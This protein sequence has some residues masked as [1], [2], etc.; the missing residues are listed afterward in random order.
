MLVLS[1]DQRM[2]MESARGAVAANAP[3]ADYRRLRAEGAGRRLLAR[4]LARMRRDG[5]ERRAVP[6]EFGGIDFGI[7]GAG[8]IAR[9][10]ARTLAPSP[11]LSTAVLAASALARGGSGRAEDKWLPRIAQR[12][13]DRRARD[14]RRR[15][16]RRIGAVK[17]RRGPAGG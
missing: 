15:R 7:V 3:I 10:M 12:R 2:L 5:L 14:R 8:L 11:F 1:E 16:R 13:G 9:E 17:A 4:V 6:E